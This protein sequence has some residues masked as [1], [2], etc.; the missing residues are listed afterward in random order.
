M[1]VTGEFDGVYQAVRL[2]LIPLDG[3]DPISRHDATPPDTGDD[4]LH[5]PPCP[6]IG[7]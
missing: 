2:A 3:G 6:I 4:S 7:Q 5:E 1:D